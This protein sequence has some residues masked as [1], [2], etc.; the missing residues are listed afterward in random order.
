E[1]ERIVDRGSD[2]IARVTNALDSGFSAIEARDKERERFLAVVAH[3]LKTPL[4]A[5]LGYGE[6]AID[7]PDD[8]TRVKALE[9]LRRQAARLGR[10]VDEV[11]LA[12]RLRSGALLFHP[13]PV[14]LVAVLQ[15]V[16]HEISDL[17]PSRRFEV[18][19]PTRASA[20]GDPQLLGHSF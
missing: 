8:P 16:V 5:V 11:L 4:T 19:E 13:Q 18:D 7:A 14:D 6:A 2:E 20:L 9:V 3:E 15:R 17:S 10:L 1:N 12:A